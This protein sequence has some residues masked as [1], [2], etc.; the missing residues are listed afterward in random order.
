MENVVGSIYYCFTFTDS[1]YASNQIS[2]LLGG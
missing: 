1:N 2:F